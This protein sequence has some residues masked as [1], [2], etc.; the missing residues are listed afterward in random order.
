MTKPA[1]ETAVRAEEHLYSIPHSDCRK[2]ARAYASSAIKEA[3]EECARAVC[4]GCKQGLPVENIND[5]YWSHPGIPNERSPYT[6][7]AWK[8][9]A[10][11]ERS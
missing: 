1:D 5:Q 3:R 2:A 10:L 7:T 11:G 8:I 6:C 9:R 4:V